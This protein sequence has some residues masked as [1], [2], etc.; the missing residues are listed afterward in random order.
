MRITEHNYSDQHWIN[1]FDLMYQKGIQLHHVS[2]EYYSF[3][4]Y[5]KLLSK[6]KSK[7]P[8]RIINHIVKLAEPNFE[9][10]IFSTKKLNQKI[11][12]YQE[13]LQVNKIDTVQWMW[14]GSL[15]NEE[16]RLELFLKQKNQIKDFVLKAKKEKK[17]KNFFV[18]PYT[19]SFAKECLNISFIDG[20]VVYRNPSET[21]YDDLIVNCENVNKKCIVIRP[22]FSGKEIKSNLTAE[23]LISFSLNL[24]SIIGTIVSISRPN[25]LNFC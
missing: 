3:N 14:R 2:C 16:K 8:G 22:F 24:K 12:L 5:C 20:I 23:K 25:Q 17:I 18:F 9:N 4:L 11:Q 6:F 10:N 1:L 21:F 19:F 7:Y 13:K 15:D